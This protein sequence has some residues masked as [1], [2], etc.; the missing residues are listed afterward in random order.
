MKHYNYYW[1]HHMIPNDERQKIQ[2][3]ID[4]K[5]Y[6]RFVELYKE[7]AIKAVIYG[8]YKTVFLPEYISV[9]DEETKK[10][11]FVSVLDRNEFNKITHSE[12]EFG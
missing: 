1:Y 7:Y 6:E 5:D 8:S 3:T 2:H 12:S 9:Y 4:S 10:A 11:E